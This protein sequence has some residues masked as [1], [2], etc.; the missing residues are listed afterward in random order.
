MDEHFIKVSAEYS[1]DF[2]STIY[3]NNPIKEH[4]SFRSVTEEA[5]LTMFEEVNTL[6]NKFSID[7]RESNCSLT[8]IYRPVAPH[9][10]PGNNGLIILPIDGQL[11]ISFY[12]YDPPIVD[13]LTM[14]SPYPKDRVFLTTDETRKL[15]NSKIS[16]FVI[17]EPIAVNGRKVFSYRPTGGTIPL[18]FLLKIP[19]NMSW[20]L[21]KTIQLEKLYA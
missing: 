14:L 17:T 3:E 11:E 12:T 1:K 15:L 13:G 4:G 16:T 6:F 5:G 9:T 18:V 10:N 7:C 2:F 21:I 8:T 20:E 19:F